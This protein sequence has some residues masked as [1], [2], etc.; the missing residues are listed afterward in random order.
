MTVI[1]VT[2]D[3]SHR[4]PDAELPEFVDLPGSVEYSLRRPAMVADF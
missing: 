3:R 1:G 2:A 4:A